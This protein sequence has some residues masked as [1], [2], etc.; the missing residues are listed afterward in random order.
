MSAPA[1][2]LV[3]VL[4]RAFDDIRFE[5]VRPLLAEDFMAE[6]LQTRER[7][8][9]PVNFIALNTNYHGGA[10]RLSRP[11]RANRPDGPGR[12]GGGGHRRRPGHG[13]S[14]V[15][16]VRSRSLALGDERQ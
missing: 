5:D 6:W 15:V 12:H 3:R 14:E 9:G 7:I 10:A 11:R 16:A 8:V 4:W 2:D 1:E 13:A